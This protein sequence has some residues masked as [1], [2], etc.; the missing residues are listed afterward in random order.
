MIHRLVSV[1]IQIEKRYKPNR[2]CSREALGATRGNV[3]RLSFAWL[4][5]SRRALRRSSWATKLA[6]RAPAGSG[7]QPSVKRLASTRN[8]LLKTMSIGLTVTLPFYCGSFYGTA[9]S[10]TS[11]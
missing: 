8:K 11:V 3:A 2:R 4:R 7:L 6:G 10:Q 5:Q 1:L 9:F